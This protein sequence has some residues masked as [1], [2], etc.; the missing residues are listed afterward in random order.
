M[1]PSPAPAG[2]TRQGS[3][4]AGNVSSLSLLLHAGP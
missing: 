3:G 4:A 1:L 2:R